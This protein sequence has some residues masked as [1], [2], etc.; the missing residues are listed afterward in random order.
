MMKV[1]SRMK[2]PAVSAAWPRMTSRQKR[3]ALEFAG[4]DEDRARAYSTVDWMDLSSEMKGLLLAGWHMGTVG[5]TTRRYS[6]GTTRRVPVLV[7][8]PAPGW[9][10]TRDGE[11]LKLFPNVTKGDSEAFAWLLRRQNQSIDWAVKYEGYDIVLVLDGKIIHSYKRDVLGK[12]GRQMKNPVPLWMQS[13]QFFKEVMGV[14]IKEW[15]KMFRSLPEWKKKE[16]HRRSGKQML[17]GA[18]MKWVIQ[19]SQVVVRSN[20]RVMRRWYVAQY[21]TRRGKIWDAQQSARALQPTIVGKIAVIKAPSSYE[22][23]REAVKQR[24]RLG[25]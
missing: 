13:D 19:Q 7:N 12:K 15:Q 14:S 10:V 2:N 17:S 8:Q 9:R 25:L 21:R 1:K 11:T 20:S 6:G 22:A 4:V 3:A 5:G 23:I 18:A 24:R 16:F